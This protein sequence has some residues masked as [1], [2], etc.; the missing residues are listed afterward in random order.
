MSIIYFTSITVE[1]KKILKPIEKSSCMYVDNC[2]I[3][4]KILNNIGLRDDHYRK[5]P[6]PDEGGEQIIHECQ[7]KQTINLNPTVK[8]LY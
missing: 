7:T 1:Q 8:G 3:I 6:N 4:Y 2:M 5:T